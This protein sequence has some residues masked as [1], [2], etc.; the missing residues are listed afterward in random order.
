ML[1]PRKI[2]PELGQLC[3]SRFCPA[4]AVKEPVDL[5]HEASKRTDV[6]MQTLHDSEYALIG[7]T[8]AVLDKQITMLKEQS[9][10]IAQTLRPAGLLL[11]LGSGGTTSGKFWDLLDQLFTHFGQ[12]SQDIPRN[13]FEDMEFTNLMGGLRENST[14]GFRIER[15]SVRGDAEDRQN[16]CGQHLMDAAEESQN[17][18]LG[19]IVVEDFISQP[20]LAFA[21]DCKKDAEGAVVDFVRRQIAGEVFQSPGFVFKSEFRAPF[22]SPSLPPNFGSS[23]RGRRPGNRA[24]DA[25][26]PSD[27]E[28]HLRSQHARPGR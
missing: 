18:F 4:A 10:P 13:F 2:S 6:A 9:D 21:V 15:G 3:L 28:G 7:G 24:T 22:F 5:I 12:S 23:Q 25:R 1:K 20:A 17:I 14:E 11:L 27:T 19:G 26:R 8:D 16:S